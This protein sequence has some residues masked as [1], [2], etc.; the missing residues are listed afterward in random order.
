MNDN[1]QIESEEV[2]LVND[3]SNGDKT[4]KIKL[5]NKKDL[6]FWVFDSR[7]FGKPI[8][9]VINDRLDIIMGIIGLIWL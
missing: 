3:L 5:I 8:K 2:D 1:A 9:N 6:I 4:S 7:F